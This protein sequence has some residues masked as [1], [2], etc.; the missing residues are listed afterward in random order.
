MKLADQ[1]AD[2]NVPNR[3]KSLARYARLCARKTSARR[4]AGKVR[5]DGFRSCSAT[6]PASWMF[7]LSGPVLRCQGL[8]WVW[9]PRS[10]P[11]V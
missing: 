9:S 1:I 6:G 7:M 10:S 8:Q 3:V 11:R 5:R 4:D 2:A